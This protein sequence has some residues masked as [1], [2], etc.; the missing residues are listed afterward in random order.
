MS[1]A[2]GLFASLRVRNYRLFASGQVVSLTG[3]FMEHVLRHQRRGELKVEAQRSDDPYQRSNGDE[4]RSASYVG[5]P[6]PHCALAARDRLA[7]EQ[8]VIPHQQQHRED[9]DE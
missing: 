9:S 3:T 8:F 2:P 6:F 5:K 7:D 1:D 4:L